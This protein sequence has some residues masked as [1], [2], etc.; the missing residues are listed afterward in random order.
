[1]PYTPEYRK[2]MVNRSL[3]D[4]KKFNSYTVQT[5]KLLKDLLFSCVTSLENF[6][7]AKFK[8]TCGVV[9]NSNELFDLL[10]DNKDGFITFNE[11]RTVLADNQVK[12]SENLGKLLFQ[13]FDKDAD[14]KISY[15]EFH[16]PN[17]NFVCVDSIK[18]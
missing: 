6:E 12:M 4:I 3:I 1:L 7:G 2:N 8:V 11:F 5:K 13:L 15:G 18:E 16:T 14:E 10:D 9:A 17:K